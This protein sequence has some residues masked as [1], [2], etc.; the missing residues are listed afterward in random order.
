M[1]KKKRSIFSIYL[2]LVLCF[3]F[4]LFLLFNPL[5][6]RMSFWT[7]SNQFP[8]DKSQSGE[9]PLANHNYI[10]DVEE[11]P[12]HQVLLLGAPTEDSEIDDSTLLLTARS[13]Q[14]QQ[15]AEPTQQHG[16][17]SPSAPPQYHIPFETYSQDDKVLTRNIQVNAF[18]EELYSFLQQR[19][20]VPPKIFVH[21][22]GWL[23][24]LYIYLIM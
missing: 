8:T 24:A 20:T 13:P 3:L 14:R 15:Q 18:S 12:D 1:Y 19:N 23:T 16:I 4:S 17:L 6:D 5:E 21:I 2:I 9:I 22:K 7:P 10:A 11:S